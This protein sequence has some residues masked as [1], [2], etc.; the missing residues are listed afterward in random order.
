MNDY[1]EFLLETEEAKQK[2]KFDNM[3]RELNEKSWYYVHK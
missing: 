2:I 1:K 3:I